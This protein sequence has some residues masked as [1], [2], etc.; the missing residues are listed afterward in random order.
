MVC[1]QY[2]PGLFL[3]HEQSMANHCA[4][5]NGHYLEDGNLSDNARR[6]VKNPDDVDR[7]WE[8]SERLVGQK[9]DY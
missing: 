4:A 9:F 7:L 5:Y 8:L 6:T 2:L 1:V 3:V